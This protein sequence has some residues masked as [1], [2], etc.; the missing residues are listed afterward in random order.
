MCCLT[1]TRTARTPAVPLHEVVK[2]ALAQGS[3]AHGVAE[4]RLHIAGPGSGDRVPVRRRAARHGPREPRR[5]RRRARGGSQADD[6]GHAGGKGAR[7]PPFPGHASTA[8]TPVA[9]PSRRPSKPPL[10][11]RWPPRYAAGRET[12]DPNPSIAQLTCSIGRCQYPST[13]PDD[14][15]NIRFLSHRP[16]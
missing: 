16:G 1:R 4:H 13:P 14:R 10:P 9:H 5:G 6:Q 3:H 11:R 15:C 7:T 2:P 12:R 8:I